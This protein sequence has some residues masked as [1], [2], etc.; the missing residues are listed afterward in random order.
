MSATYQD[1]PYTNFPEDEEDLIV[2][3]NVN[4]NTKNIVDTYLGYVSDGRFSDAQTYY[5][6][7]KTV[8]DKIIINENTINKLLQSIIAIERMFSN[9]IDEYINRSTGNLVPIEVVNA[10]PSQTE[11]GKLYLILEPTDSQS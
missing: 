3:Q 4:Q 2:Y 10:L 1:L 8:L 11:V 6:A 5:N 7:N 9:D